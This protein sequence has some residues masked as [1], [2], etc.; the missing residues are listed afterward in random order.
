MDAWRRILVAPD[1]SPLSMKGV[2]RATALAKGAG[3]GAHV[4]LVFVVEKM[5]FPPLP[6][7][8]PG[9]VTFGREGDVLG[10][11]VAHGEERLKELVATQFSEAVSAGAAVET[12]VALAAGAAAGILEAAEQWRPDVI[13]ISS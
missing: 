11:A 9:P 6:L 1:L 12:K 3:A 2:A 5:W 13:V 10:E 4:L 7:A 8:S